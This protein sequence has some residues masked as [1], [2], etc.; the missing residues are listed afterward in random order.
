MRSTF[1]GL[2]IAKTGLFVAQNQQDITG[3]N[4][5]NSATAG[6]TRQ[7]LV[8]QSMP[9]SFGGTFIG[10]DNKSTAGRGVNTI[11]IEQVRNP[12]LDYQYRKENSASTNWATQEQYFG[13]IEALFSVELDEMSASSGLSSIF[14]KFYNSLYALSENPE[15]QEI[16]TNVRTTASTLV[17]SMNSYYDSLVKQQDTLNESVRITVNEINSIA[18]DIAALNEKIYGYELSGAKAN[19]LRDQRNLLLDTLSGIVEINTFEDTN[20]RLVVQAGGR[21]LVRH[22][23]YNQLAVENNV[24]NS[25]EGEADMFGV[26]WADS[27]GN[28]TIIEFE[29]GEGALKGYMAIRDGATESNMGIPY[30]IQQLNDMCNKVVQQINGV[31]SEGWT[32]PGGL[33]GPSRTGVNFFYY[34]DIKENNFT[35]PANASGFN[36]GGSITAK[37]KFTLTA[38]GDNVEVRNSSGALVYTGTVDAASGVLDLTAVGLGK[39]TWQ[40]NGETNANVAAA[41]ASVGS[42]EAAKITAKKGSFKIDQAIMDDVF[43]IAA[44]DVLV[45]GVGETNQQRGN[46]KVAMALCEL[47]YNKDDMSKPDNL[48]G[49]Y[50][51]LLSSISTRMDYVKKTSSSQYVMLTHLEQQRKSVS[52]VS[53]DEE[54]TNI[55]R[56]GH[57]Y[58]AASRMITAID[59][60]LDKLINGTGIVGR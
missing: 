18:Q 3:H 11:H 24:P 27:E 37:G 23:S 30:V 35:E 1:Y 41:I 39:V 12:F 50:R 60:E 31:H 15:D 47:I 51:E 17:D 8:T 9:A 29:I 6:Y 36:W 4:M 55:V 28:P 53:V 16:R 56:F 20:G 34:P 42:V 13:Y 43:N 19:D 45:A 49:D 7:R 26:Y 54:M 25:I 59:E 5:S 33:N 52:D 44:S 58:N 48:N 14:E 40:D 21:D 46:G 22:T 2:E 38:N 32:T 57:S 10:I